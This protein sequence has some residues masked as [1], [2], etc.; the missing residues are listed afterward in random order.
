M[1]KIYGIVGKA[2]SRGTHMP[3]M[4]ALSLGIKKVKANV[5]PVVFSNVGQKSRDF[6]PDCDLDFKSFDPKIYR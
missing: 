6:T 1:F 3:N 5:I 2:L 4:K